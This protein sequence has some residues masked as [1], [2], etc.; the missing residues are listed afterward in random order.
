MSVTTPPDPWIPIRTERLLLRDFRETDFD[1]VHAYGSDPEVI[2]YMPWGPNTPD[3][4]RAFLARALASQTAAPRLD[5]H[6]AIQHGAAGTVI[7]SIGLHPFDEANRTREIG[8]CLHRAWWRQG[9]VHEAARALIDASVAALDLHRIVATCDV[10]NIGS[11]GVM[12]KLGMRRE[13]RFRRDRQIRGEWRDTY[14]YAILAE[15]WRGQDGR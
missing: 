1:A 12:E 6:L 13:G 3:D 15:D 7:G 10:R 8:Y 9:F 4:T 5:F 2:H 11:F 14:L